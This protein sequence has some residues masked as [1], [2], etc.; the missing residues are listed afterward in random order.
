MQS[1][2]FLL[3]LP[4]SAKAIF[5]VSTVVRCEYVTHRAILRRFVLNASIPFANVDV[6]LTVS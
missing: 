2:H 1:C 4:P 5:P 6:V 3:P